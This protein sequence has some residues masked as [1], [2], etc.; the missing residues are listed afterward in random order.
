M[1]KTKAGIYLAKVNRAFAA[2]MRITHY[3][4]EDG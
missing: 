1:I 4:F 2:A 3:T